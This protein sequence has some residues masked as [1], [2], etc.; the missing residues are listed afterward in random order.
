MTT[1]SII[2]PAFHAQETLLRAI[3]SLKAQSHDAWQAIVVSDDGADYAAFLEGLGFS[4]P[5]VIHTST[6]RVGS[7]CHRARNA[8]L[9]LMTGA[10]LTWLDAD[11]TFTSD[12]LERLLPLAEKYGAAADRLACL[13]AESGAPLFAPRSATP[14]SSSALVWGTRGRSPPSLPASEA[15]IPL[16]LAAF[17]TLDQPLV[18]LIMRPFVQARLE[19][20][21]LAED[22]IANIRLLDQLPVLAWLQ[23]ELYH[24]FIRNGSLAHSEESGARFDAA[25]TDY[26]MRIEH[27]DGFGLSP[28]ARAL[29]RD[30]LSRK[31]DLNRAF[32]AARQNAPD[33]TFQAFM[34]QA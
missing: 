6:G 21:E 29:A 25:Y 19:G 17:L 31:R 5:R 27:G 3:V 16:D 23:A 12:R 33:L 4:D 2:I 11:D 9:P 20:I 18:P 10:A 30:G 15:V 1:I 14:V 8:G 26:L 32:E 22:V 34:A 7:G 13:D 24:Y 28:Q